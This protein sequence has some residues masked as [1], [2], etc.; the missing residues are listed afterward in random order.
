MR[1]KTEYC[2]YLQ[3]KESVLSLSPPPSDRSCWRTLLSRYDLMRTFPSKLQWKAVTPAYL[4]A[5]QRSSMRPAKGALPP[6]QR[7]QALVERD[8]GLDGPAGV[9]ARGADEAR[10]QLRSHDGSV[11]ERTK[12]WYLCPQ[13]ETTRVRLRSAQSLGAAPTVTNRN[14]APKPTSHCTTSALFCHKLV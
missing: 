12:E 2:C 7:I 3:F 8:E 5:E 9:D 1:Q 4:S 6:E 14:T 10:Q 13:A 11:E